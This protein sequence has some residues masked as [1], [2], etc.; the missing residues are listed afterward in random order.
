MGIS[1]SY[2]RLHRRTQINCGENNPSSG[3][4]NIQ[5]YARMGIYEPPRENLEKQKKAFKHIAGFPNV[6]GVIDSTH[7]CIQGLYNISST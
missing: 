3:C 7:I 4:C 5:P 1:I 2:W 6:V